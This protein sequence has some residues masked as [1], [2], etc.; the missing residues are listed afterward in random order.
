[1]STSPLL[2]MSPS[3][4]TSSVVSLYGFQTSSHP[5]K[6][7]CE[8]LVEDSLQ[9]SRG[10]RL[11]REE[12]RVTAAALSPLQYLYYL[13]LRRCHSGAAAAAP[14]NRLSQSCGHYSIPVGRVH[15]TDQAT[16]ATALWTFFSTNPRPQTSSPRL[17]A[18]SRLRRRTLRVLSPKS[19]I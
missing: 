4:S 3:S 12:S 14:R 9:S 17:K 16:A 8:Y 5:P 13:V 7:I 19:G 15:V 2:G 1:M 10:A 6:K 11:L 18:L